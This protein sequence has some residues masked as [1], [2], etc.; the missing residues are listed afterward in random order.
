[1]AAQRKEEFK[2]V[3]VLTASKQIV[4]GV[5]YKF[6]IELLKGN[7]ETVKCRYQVWDRAWIKPSKQIEEECDGEPQKKYMVKRSIHLSEKDDQ[8]IHLGL[9]YKFINK[10]SKVYKNKA[11]FKNRFEIFKQNM[12]KIDIFTQNEQG[13][14][15]YGPT[16]FADLTEA[17]FARYKG[18]RPE[19][20]DKNSIP[21]PNAKTPDISI[22]VEFDW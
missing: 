9:F 2:N 21:F 15:K 1:M 10:H 19:L 14:A 4:A 22:P 18:L 20:R 11:E 5:L 13:T 7:G 17:E 8:D 6:E 3:T 12:K 16:M